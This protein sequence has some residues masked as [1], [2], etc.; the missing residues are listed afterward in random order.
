MS[1]T[2][3]NRPLGVTR[4]KS[5]VSMGDWVAFLVPISGAFIV[6][7]GGSLP[8]SEILF[9]LCFPYLVLT[10]RKQAFDKGYRSAYLL[11]A[12]WVFSQTLTDVFVDASPANR[13]KGLAR[14]VFFALDLAS[15]A[16]IIGTSL[17]RTKIFTLGLVA[18]LLYGAHAGGGGMALEWK[19]GLALATSM[20]V[21][22][23][24]SSLYVKRKYAAVLLLTLALAVANLHYAV[25]GG[26]MIDV[27]V[28]VLLL[29]IFPKRVSDRTSAARGSGGRLILLL[30]LSLAAVWGSQQILKVAVNAG[31]FSESDQTKFEQQSQGKLGMIFGGRPEGLVAARAIM[32]SPILGHGSYAVDYKY[33]ALLQEYQYRFGYAEGDESEDVEDPG[34]PTHSHLTMSWV[35][36]GL[37][38]S[39]F[40]FYMLI[41]IFRCI[42]RL[43]ETPHPLGP[44][45]LYLLITLT[46]DILFS[47]FGLGRRMFEAFFIVIMVNL[48]RSEPVQA[49]RIDMRVRG[50]RPILRP[51]TIWRPARSFRRV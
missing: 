51:A 24:A 41:L 8:Y 30:V 13:I 15:I 44:L 11:L 12:L 32:D 36:G 33:Y 27:A 37:L 25:R 4:H 38:A 26:M 50:S 49:G 5:R 16:A 34:I 14:V 18:S 3:A 28:A 42:I 10:H 40:W 2:I 48:L 23:F 46:W 19:M 17:R 21:F 47:P 20:A 31:I 7:V 22:L 39:F 6:S 43:T 35:E 29:P 9:L 1:T 45:Y